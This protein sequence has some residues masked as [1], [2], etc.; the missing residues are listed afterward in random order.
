MAKDPTSLTTNPVDKVKEFFRFLI[1]LVVVVF[2]VRIFI[3]EPFSIPTGSMIPSLL[4]GDY[5]IVSK[6]TYGLSRYSFPFGAKIPYFKGRILDF[7]KPQRGD[8]VVFR[9]P[10]TPNIDYI[11]RVVG[12]PGDQLQVRGGRLYVNDQPALLKKV[13]PYVEQAEQGG[14][15]VEA[16]KYIETLSNGKSHPFIKEYPFGDGPVD[17]TPVYVV[18]E[19]HYFMMGDNR[20]NSLDSRYLHQMGY[21]PAENLVGRAEVIFFSWNDDRVP[22]WQLWNIPFHIRFKRIFNLIS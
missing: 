15:I 2:G 1:T 5:L 22:F 21:I 9:A 12:L 16:E 7:H 4:V 17:D 6:F 20:D 10:E 11:K 3:F 8:V 14:K 18:P 13:G 19:G